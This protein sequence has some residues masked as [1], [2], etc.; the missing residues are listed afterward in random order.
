MKVEFKFF[1]LVS[2]EELESDIKRILNSPINKGITREEAIKKIEN[3][4]ANILRNEINEIIENGNE[5]DYIS[6]FKD[7][8]VEI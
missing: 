2:K 6:I 7:G 8:E 5:M 3:G 4:V 1:K